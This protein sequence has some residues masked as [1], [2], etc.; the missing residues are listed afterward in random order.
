MLIVIMLSV[1]LLIVVAPLG[2]QGSCSRWG[3]LKN[4]LENK[5]QKKVFF[6]VLGKAITNK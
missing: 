3:I 2:S 6:I 5:K 4:S 1:V